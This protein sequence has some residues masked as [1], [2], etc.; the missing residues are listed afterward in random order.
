MT[1]VRKSKCMDKDL[2]A[3]ASS[4]SNEENLKTFHLLEDEQINSLSNITIREDSKDN[5]NIENS[6]EKNCTADNVNN[7]DGTH[8]DENSPKRKRNVLPTF[9][10]NRYENLSQETDYELPFLKILGRVETEFK[11]TSMFYNKLYKTLFV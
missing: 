8:E 7:L 9:D 3:T 10:N 11:F 6:I 5:A 2:K 1:E 4:I